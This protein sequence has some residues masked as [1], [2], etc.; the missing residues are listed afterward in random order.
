MEQNT[1]DNIKIEMGGQWEFLLAFM[2]ALMMFAVALG[3]RT[4]HF[5]FFKK[6]PKHYIAGVMA[7]IIGLPLLTILLVYILRPAPSL[8]LGMIIVASCPGGNVSNIFTLF[9]R[10]NTALSVSLTATSSL[11]AALIT[12]ISILFWLSLYPPTADLLQ[13]IDFD[14]VRFLIQTLLILALPIISGMVF[15]H[16]YPKQANRLQKPLAVIGGL[17]MVLIVLFGFWKY[18]NLI[19]PL[20]SM[21][22]PLVVLHNAAAFLLG[23]FSGVITKADKPTRRALTFEIGLQNSALGFVILATALSG[24]GGAMVLVGLW[25][26]WHIIGGGFVTLI[27]RQADKIKNK[28]GKNV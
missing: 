12:P 27:F 17:S 25:G 9:A 4:E 24:L 15:A 28:R 18:R 6:D 13:D 3:L 16:Y 14:V 1:L 26:L 10:G 20:A 21:V 7:Q 8:A 22:M 23:F 19:P 11:A 2:L 5:A